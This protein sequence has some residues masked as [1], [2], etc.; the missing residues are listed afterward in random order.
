MR[1]MSLSKQPRTSSQLL[2]ARNAREE[3]DGQVEK[4][5]IKERTCQCHHHIVMSSYGFKEVALIGPER[6]QTSS[7]V[8]TRRC[9]RPNQGSVLY[10]EHLCHC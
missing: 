5:R 2:N 10:L 7:C 9:A 8:C 1:Q 4:V 6:V 3:C